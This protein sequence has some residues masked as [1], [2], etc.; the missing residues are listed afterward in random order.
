M[1]VESVLNRINLL[2]HNGTFAQNTFVL[3]IELFIPLARPS[4]LGYINFLFR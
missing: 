1:V 3:R 4:V 2:L